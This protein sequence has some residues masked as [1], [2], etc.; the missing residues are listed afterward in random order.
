MSQAD[1]AMMVNQLKKLPNWQ[2]NFACQS[3]VKKRLIR[4]RTNS[5]TAALQLSG[6]DN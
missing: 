4:S 6:L 2:E 5:A 1:M 3:E